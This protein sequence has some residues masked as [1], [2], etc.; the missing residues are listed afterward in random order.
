MGSLFDAWG[1]EQIQGSCES[2]EEC[3]QP[4]EWLMCPTNEFPMDL[5]S[6]GGLQLSSEAEGTRAA[7]PW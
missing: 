3:P 4:S 6:L 5:P 7:V 1:V 2:Q